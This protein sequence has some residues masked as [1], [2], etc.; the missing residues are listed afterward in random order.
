[1]RTHLAAVAQQPASR[2]E[3]HIA[4]CRWFRVELTWSASFTTTRG[5]HDSQW[6]AAGN[7]LAIPAKKAENRATVAVSE[8]VG[9]NVEPVFATA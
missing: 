8:R 2:N 5:S 9:S 4:S 7:V 3:P 6:S 1:V